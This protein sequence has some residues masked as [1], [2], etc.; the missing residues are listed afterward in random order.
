[1]FCNRLIFLGYFPGILS[2]VRI[3]TSN[4]GQGLISATGFSNCRF[5][6]WRNYSA[7]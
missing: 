5:A 2:G 3:F 6:T 1:M 4:A 7:L